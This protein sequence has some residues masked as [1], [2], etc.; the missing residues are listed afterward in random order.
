M[1]ERG[2]GSLIARRSGQALCRPDGHEVG[3]HD[4]EGPRRSG[5]ALAGGVSL[6]GLILILILILRRSRVGR[7]HRD[8]KKP[9][10]DTLEKEF[11]GDS[12]HVEAGKRPYAAPRAI[13]IATCAV[14]QHSLGLAP[15]RPRAPPRRRRVRRRR[16]GETESGAVVCPFASSVSLVHG[17]AFVVIGGAHVFC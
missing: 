6:G 12:L 16:G 7:M 13:G 4:F 8:N 5:V 3:T 2:R 11:S 10:H 17:V 14:R 9:L 1:G 15:A